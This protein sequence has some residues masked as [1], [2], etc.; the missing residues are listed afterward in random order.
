MSDAR[1]HAGPDLHAIFGIDGDPE[2]GPDQAISRGLDDPDVEPSVE[3]VAS[4]DLDPEAD[5]QQ[6]V[7]AGAD[8][9]V[10]LAGEPGP[11]HEGTRE[12]RAVGF[13]DVLELVPVEVDPDPAAAPPE[14][15]DGG[16][17]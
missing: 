15:L 1:Q 16:Q 13:D 10:R 8:A 12:L 5:H 6:L 11:D 2:G 4:G 3:I 7:D 17:A 14:E 9:D